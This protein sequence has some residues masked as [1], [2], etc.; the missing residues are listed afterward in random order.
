MA[1]D[2][3]GV[4]GLGETPF[5]A[6]GRRA[7]RAGPDDHN[8]EAAVGDAHGRSLILASVA[9]DA[10]LDTKFLLLVVMATAI[11]TLGLLQSSAPVVIGAMLVSPLLGPI[12]G[13]GFG[14]AT[15]ESNLIKRSLVTLAAGTLVAIIIAALIIWLSP[16]KDV[17]PEIRARTQPTLIDLGVAVVGGIAGVYA[18]LRKLSGVM[19]GVAIAT[20]LLPPLSTVAFGL[21]TGRPDFAMGGGLLFLTN[22]LAIA[23]SV[24]IVA[25]LNKFGPSLTP[26]HTAMQVVGIVATLGILSIP[27]AISFNNI[28]RE[29][30]ARTAVQSELRALLGDGDQIDSLNVRLEGDAIEIDGVVLVDRYAGQLNRELEAKVRGDLDRDVRVN[31]AQLRKQTNAAAQL[32]ERLSS[33]IAT[34]EQREEESRAI[35]SSLTVGDL[36]P[37]GQLLIDAQARRV[38]VQRDREAEGEQVA[39]AID[40]IMASVQAGYPQWLIQNGSLTAAKAPVA[41]AA[42][43]E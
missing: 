5:N 29:I 28:V 1:G 43:T 17:T 21:V 32:E 11:A 39:A 41:E 40:R 7:T 23:F 2:H 22:T 31:L 25:R 9:R 24:T 38:I 42:A 33:R 27:L 36:L 4:P 18:I 15:I 37:R 19:V 30:R 26:Q 8:D 13:I 34:L 10:R 12:M 14:L 20:A 16:I 6:G 3:P 35:L